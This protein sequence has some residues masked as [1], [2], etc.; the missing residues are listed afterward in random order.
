M[1]DRDLVDSDVGPRSPALWGKEADGRPRIGHRHAFF[2]PTD[3]DGDG[4]LDHLAVVATMGFNALECQALDQMRRLPLGEGDP[5]PLLLVGLGRADDFRTPLLQKA[6]S[7]VSATPFLVTRHM[8]D[9]G[10]KRDPRAFFDAPD[11]RQQFVMQ[12]L[13]RGTPASRA[14]SGGHADRAS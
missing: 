2:L 5:L 3:E 13:R 4:R 11:G 14:L 9:S 8:K 1:R 6:T 10:R 7:W 12:V